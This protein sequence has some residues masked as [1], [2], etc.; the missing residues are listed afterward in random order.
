MLFLKLHIFSIILLYLKTSTAHD[1]FI[2][3]GKV[4]DDGLNKHLAEVH[5]H[6]LS[7]HLGTC[8]G[9]IIHKRWVITAAHC[10][11]KFFWSHANIYHHYSKRDNRKIGKASKVKI[12][13]D[14]VNEKMHH[15]DIALIRLNKEIKFNNVIQP[16][17]LI[18]RRSQYG[19]E[20][21]IVGYGLDEQGKEHPWQAYVELIDCGH[22]K[23]LLCSFT[24]TNVT[25]GDSGG[26]VVS[27][28]ALVG[29]ILGGSIRTGLTL[30]ADISANR[31]WIIKTINEYIDK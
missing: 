28:G 31:K 5:I 30:F 29:I 15:A 16:I 6:F 14:F 3:K 23:P 1:D 9:S 11:T 17:P 2:C 25:K 19:S 4:L 13:E 20:V 7:V 27:Y 22:Y 24:R 8:G 18:G 21:L 10:F 12:H 26:P